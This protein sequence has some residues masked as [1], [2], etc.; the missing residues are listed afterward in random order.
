MGLFSAI[1][2]GLQAAQEKAESEAAPLIQ[3]I[4]DRDLSGGA[5]TAQYN[6]TKAN[7]IEDRDLSGGADALCRR[8]GSLSFTARGVA[9]Q[10]YR[11][12]IR[13]SNSDEVY[14]VFEEMSAR[15]RRRGETIAFNVSQWL[16]EELAKSGDSRVSEMTSSDGSK[17][18][19]IPR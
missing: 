11:R 14:R 10:A 16:G 15:Y 5:D 9:M 7:L 4:E 3:L 13:F 19:Y 17:T 6:K 12:K 1:Q 2:R 18:L 8:L